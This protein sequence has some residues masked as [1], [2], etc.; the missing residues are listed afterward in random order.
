MGLNPNHVL[1]APRVVALLI[2]LPFL[3]VIGMLAGIAGGMTLGVLALDM[4]NSLLECKARGVDDAAENSMRNPANVFDTA[5]G[6]PAN[7]LH[8]LGESARA[9]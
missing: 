2:S 8:Y 6:G 7:G 4:S 1:I 3:A 9:G 5:G